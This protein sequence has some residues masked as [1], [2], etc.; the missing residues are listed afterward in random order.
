M[1]DPPNAM[2]EEMKRFSII[3]KQRETEEKQEESGRIREERKRFGKEKL[4]DL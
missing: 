2:G 1:P 4:W 3:Y